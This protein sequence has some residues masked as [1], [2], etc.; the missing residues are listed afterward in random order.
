MKRLSRCNITQQNI[1]FMKKFLFSLIISASFLSASAQNKGKQNILFQP[2]T[3][4]FGEIAMWENQPATFTVTNTLKEPLIFLPLFNTNDLQ[5][6][7]PDRPLNP[8]E[9]FEIQAI[10]YTSGKGLFTRKFKVYMG[11]TPTPVELTITGNIK[12]LSP[13]A[14]QQCPTLRPQAAKSK[15]E[16]TAKVFEKESKI[17]VI[18]ATVT[19]LSMTDKSRT[20]LLTDKNGTVSGKLNTGSYEILIEKPGFYPFKSTF[21]LS[22]N[23]LHLD[24]P[25]S[26]LIPLPSNTTER[27]TVI[28]GEPE[29]ITS[30]EAITYTT[31][32]I[33]EPFEEKI[34]EEK[35]I[36]ESTV[37]AFKQETIVNQEKI[38]LVEEVKTEFE[39]EPAAKTVF[40]FEF[41]SNEAPKKEKENEFYYTPVDATLNK[42][43]IVEDEPVEKVVFIEDIEA[44]M[45]VDSLNN[46]IAQLLAEKAE[47]EQK[48][49][50]IEEQKKA[51]IE[52]E[53]EKEK[54]AEIEKITA[55]VIAESFSPEL[56]RTQYAANNVIFLIDISSSMAKE[57]KMDLMKQAMKNMVPALRDIDRVAIIAYN[58]KTFTILESVK[59]NQ[60]DLILNAIDS[61]VPRGLTYGV[62]G[63]QN[64]YDV[65]ET[66]YISN[67]NNQIILA[68][69]GLFSTVNQTMTERQLNKLV[70]DKAT[71]Q[72]I[73]LSVVGFG[74]DPVG[75]KLMTELALNGSGKFI[76]IRNQWDAESVLIEEIK[77]NSQLK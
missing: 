20:N 49:Q 3:Y 52:A 62:N 33:A 15:T 72:N 63:I 43:E 54:T 29:K 10:Y 16:L 30:T 21:F 48:L 53:K 6:I 41:E 55:P 28:A 34:E 47:V 73:K 64:A 37:A 38:A 51:E 17:G 50:L 24:V 57:N 42:Q 59:G 45:K 1:L 22:N 27:I 58:Q 18:D 26:L 23:T 46:F 60:K 56:S 7:L 2:L 25:L 19:I 75:D 39:E 76:K 67:G 11:H 36:E 9:S 74:N 13:N 40:E 31:K 71:K 44:Q 35:V 8:G 61:L 14:Y 68:T 77:V 69:D 70:K 5:V 4:N 66:Y 12:A 32:N 65:L